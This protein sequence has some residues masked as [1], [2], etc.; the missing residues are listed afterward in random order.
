MN[1]DRQNPHTANISLN[2]DNGTVYRANLLSGDIKRVKSE[3]KDGRIHFSNY[4][5]G[6]A[7]SMFYITKTDNILCDENIDY[8]C[9]NLAHSKGKKVIALTLTDYKNDTPNVLTLD[10]CRYSLDGEYLGK[11][12]VWNLKTV[13]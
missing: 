7:S 8:D 11:A 4:M 5:P 13:I 10:R 2:I 9:V 6:C 3:V 12:E 1:N